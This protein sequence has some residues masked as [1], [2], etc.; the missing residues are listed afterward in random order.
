MCYNSLVNISVQWIMHQRTTWIES[1]QKLQF[2]LKSSTWALNDCTKDLLFNRG[3]P[4]GPKARSSKFVYR[5]CLRIRVVVRER[6]IFSDQR[7]IG[8]TALRTKRWSPFN[9]NRFNYYIIALSILLLK[10]SD[11]ICKSEKGPK[12][13]RQVHL[14]RREL[15]A[16]RVVCSVQSCSR[17]YNQQGIPA[18]INYIIC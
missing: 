9:H 18:N 15:A 2:T 11:L 6:R 16:P 12:K 17:V 13:F 10:Q 3:P 5:C 8:P 7:A 4:F 1:D 14:S